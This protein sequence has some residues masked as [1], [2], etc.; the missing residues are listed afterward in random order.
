MIFKTAARKK[1]IDGGCDWIA[2]VDRAKGKA[3][4][5]ASFGSVPKFY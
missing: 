3:L 4:A 1:E 2:I 5:A